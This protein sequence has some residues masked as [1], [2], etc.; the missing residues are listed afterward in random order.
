MPSLLRLAGL[1]AALAIPQSVL[2]DHALLQ[3]HCATCHKDVNPPAGFSIGSLGNNPDAQS[4]EL[5]VKSRAYVETGFMPP[6]NESRLSVAERRQLV[7]YLDERIGTHQQAAA[8]PRPAPPRRLNNRELANSVRDV[9][10]IEDVGT[11][12]P[13][14]N[15]LGDTLEDGFDTVG[16]TLGLSEFHL[17]QYI[18]AFR[19]VVDATI[20]SGTPPAAR[21]YTVSAEEMRMTSLSQAAGREWA[22]RTPESIDFLDPRLR[23]Y[24]SNFKMAPATGWYRIKIRA[25]GKDRGVY[26]ADETGIYDGDPIRLAVHLGDRKRVFDLPDGEA[27]DIEMDEWIAAGTR[28]ELSYPTDGLRFRGNGNFKFQFSIGHDYIKQHDPELYEAVLKEMLP[29][30]PARTAKNFR[31]WSHWTEH[32]QGARPRLFHAEVEG[33]LYAGWPPERQIELL[34][35]N[36]R[37]QDAA[38]IL[39]PIAERAWRRQVGDRE[40]D[41]IVRLVRSKA[42]GM[43]DLDAIKEG[44]V[45]ILASPSFLLLNLGDSEPSESLATKL[46]YFLESTIPDKSIREAARMGRLDDFEGIRSLLQG[47]IDGSGAEEFLR[48][49]PHSWLELDRINFMAPDP[50]RYPLY[51]RKRLSEDMV[52]EALRFFRHVVEN[53]LPV[54]ELLSADYSFINADLAEVYEVAGV[55]QD[56][57]LRKHTFADGRR[58]G[59]LGMGAFLTLTADSLGTSPIHRAVYVMEKFL[60][61]HPPQPPADVNITEPDIRQAKTIKQ[62]LAAHTADGSCASCHAGIDPYGYAFENFDPVGAWRDSYTEHIA[63]EPSKQALFEIEEQDR[64]RAGAGLPSLPRPWESEP[65]PVDASATLP[66]GIKYRDIIEFRRHLVSQEN[67]ERFVRCFITKLVVYANGAEPENETEIHSILSQSAQSEH[68]ILDTIAAVVDS[69]LF[70]E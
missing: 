50:D 46:S 16:D 21:R 52:N 53:N 31:H 62:I 11:H 59:L 38:R 56:S 54:T 42:G 60:G 20:L 28:L 40:L 43:S 22:I 45:A 36:P 18:E 4:I 17:E 2:A 35:K 5:W 1:L 8:R 47:R 69:A 24:F 13:L 27:I 41:P 33:P 9:L 61:I 51:D 48:Q 49:F 68:R 30:A 19:R 39:R 70:R 14:A 12:H 64:R 44:I 67:L 25:T 57:T 37:A 34:G 55:P 32:W 65:I 3:A 6:A 66:D 29:Q 15:L 10:L 23:V 7:W 63:P 26:D 58:G